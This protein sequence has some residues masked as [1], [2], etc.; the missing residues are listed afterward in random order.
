MTHDVAALAVELTDMAAADHRS[1]VGANSDDPAEQLAWRR[2]TARHGDRLGEIMDEYGWPTAALVGEE[3]AHAAW[4][5]A[6]HADRQLDV[7][8]RALHLMQQAVSTGAA[9]R[10]ELAFL[11]DRTLVNE[12]RKQVYGTQIAGVKDGAPVPWPCEEPERMD[13]LR[14]QVGIEPFDEYVA[15]FAMP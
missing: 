4:L 12:G 3:A 14:A 5:I 9:G 8:R 10:R 15:K 2:L 13:D 1:S 6:Q 11:R 7:Q